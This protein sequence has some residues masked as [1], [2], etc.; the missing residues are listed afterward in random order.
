MPQRRTLSIAAFAAAAILA[1]GVVAPMVTTSTQA[2]ADRGGHGHG[3]WGHHDHWRGHW[4]WDDD[5]CDGCC[6]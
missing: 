3:H 5:C 4:G 1:L 2:F 6:C